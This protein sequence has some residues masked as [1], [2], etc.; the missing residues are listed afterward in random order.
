M[1]LKL[2]RTLNLLHF[3]KF[4]MSPEALQLFDQST[5]DLIFYFIRE[6]NL[7]FCRP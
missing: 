1:N 6:I 3:N 4:F 2:L 7:L 5:I